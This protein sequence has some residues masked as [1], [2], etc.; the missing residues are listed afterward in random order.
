MTLRVRPFHK[1]L[2]SSFQTLLVHIRVTFK[3][4]AP[5]WWPVLCQSAAR[6]VI[7]VWRD[8]HSVGF[9][10]CLQLSLPPYPGSQVLA[11]TL[12][13]CKTHLQHEVPWPGKAVLLSC[14]K[15]ACKKHCH[16]LE[17]SFPYFPYGEFGCPFHGFRGPSRY[18]LVWSVWQLDAW[19]W[20]AASLL[21]CWH[22]AFV[23]MITPMVKSFWRVVRN[24]STSPVGE[25][26]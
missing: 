12:I 20:T 13:C 8:T 10:P 5:G 26:C 4:Q 23:F 25:R 24:V 21:I 11:F 15:R 9:S 22:N 1:V 6:G 16:V 17:H 18:W 19:T 3:P 7:P 2:L 14:D